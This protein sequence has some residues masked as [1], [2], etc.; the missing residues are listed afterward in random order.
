MFN[1]EYW[2]KNGC[3]HPRFKFWFRIIGAII[4][5]FLIIW[6]IHSIA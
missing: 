2:C 3:D 1:K 6:N 5:L 4:V